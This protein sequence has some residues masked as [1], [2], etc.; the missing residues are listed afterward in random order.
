MKMAYDFVLRAIYS[1]GI[2]LKIKNEPLDVAVFSLTLKEDFF[3]IAPIV[4]VIPKADKTLKYDYRVFDNF[5]KG[6]ISLEQMLKETE[7]KGFFRNKSDL[8]IDGETID[9]GSLWELSENALVL[10]NDD[11]YVEAFYSDD[12]FVLVE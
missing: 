12:D 2:D 9:K 7:C 11:Q 1:G 5:S 8:E 10:V 3:K 4:V 6:K